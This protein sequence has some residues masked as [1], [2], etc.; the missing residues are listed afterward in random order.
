MILYNKIDINMKK[1][2]FNFLY[3]V[4]IAKI[5]KNQYFF[6]LHRSIKQQEM[7]LFKTILSNFVIFFHIKE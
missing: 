4:N 6:H 2:F 7:L 1:K 3:R 5:Y